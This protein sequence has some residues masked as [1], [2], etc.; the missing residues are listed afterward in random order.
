MPIH[1]I[2]P[3][4]FTGSCEDR[5]GRA[6]PAAPTATTA[7]VGRA[8]R[9]PVDTPV[10]LSSVDDLVREFGGAASDSPLGQAV[11]AFFAHGGSHAV[12][13]R[14]ASGARR[15]EIRRGRLRLDAASPGTWANQLRVRVRR[16]EPASFE[17]EVRDGV[18]G[19][20]ERH[21]GLVFADEPRRADRVLRAESRCVRW[22]APGPE[23]SDPLPEATE[24]L[25]V[26]R[27][28]RGSGGSSLGHAELVGRGK[29]PERCGLF[30]LELGE[31]FQLLVVPPDSARGDW[32][33][34]VWQA[35]AS[36]CERRRALLLI[37]PPHDCE[38]PAVARSR[39]AKLGLPAQSAAFCWPR[40]DEPG[41][42]L[43][44]FVP[45]AEAAAAYARTDA[46]RGVWRPPPGLG[47]TLC[48]VG[49]P[50][51]PLDQREAVAARRTALFV[52]E[53][54]RRGLRWV[55]SEANDES[56]WA[57]VGARAEAFLGGL[58]RRGAFSGRRAAEAYFARCGAETTARRELERGVV[59]LSVGFAPRRPGEF[60]TLSLRLQAKQARR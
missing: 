7:F 17:L 25:G 10:P 6:I 47:A 2:Y 37:D 54:L 31:P 22:T 56:L 30:A 23:A 21:A 39:L 5:D 60:T 48:G 43:R 24:W 18:T 33:P 36:Y 40:N 50:A 38:D 42:P 57:E 3:A 58:H 49:R 51:D 34:A 53:S 52:E 28:G 1:P 4:S 27:S 11:R 20:V 8:A 59:H 46:Q 15:A 32:D 45:G 44:D 13:V 29:E 12:V 55:R 41:G 35:A 14:V 16:T 26:E 9:G 19:A